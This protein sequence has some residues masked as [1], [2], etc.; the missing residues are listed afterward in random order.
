MKIKRILL[1]TNLF[2]S[3]FYIIKQIHLMIEK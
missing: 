3:L 2:K 1:T